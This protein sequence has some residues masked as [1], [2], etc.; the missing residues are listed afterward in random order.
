MGFII[1]HIF[2]LI[3]SAPPSLICLSSP[4]WG[5]ISPW[6]DPSSTFLS[7]IFH[8]PLLS[9]LPLCWDLFLFSRSLSSILMTPTHAY[10][11]M[12][13]PKLAYAQMVTHICI[14]PDVNI[15][16]HMNRCV[17]THTY[18]Q[19]CTHTHACAQM[20]THT[21]IY[22]DVHTYIYMHRCAHIHAC[23][24]ICTH[25]C[26]CTDVH[27][28]LRAHTYTILNVDFAQK[29]SLFVFLNLSLIFSW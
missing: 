22:S 29:E 26:I 8:C 12:C 4:F 11:Q 6:I 25:T 1:S 7:H 15:H 16:L 20:C 27:P 18:T 23:A 17:P 28:Y 10:T 9:H 13:T 19:M 24:Q 3:L 5:S 14:C 2:S 21:C